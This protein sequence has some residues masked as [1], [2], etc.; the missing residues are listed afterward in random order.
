MRTRASC[1]FGKGEE[2]EGSGGLFG[3]LL[4]DRPRLACDVLEDALERRYMSLYSSGV[5]DNSRRR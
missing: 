4:L 1:R 3:L 5:L 2:G